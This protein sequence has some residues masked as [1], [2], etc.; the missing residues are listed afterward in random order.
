M[1]LR[2]K[3]FRLSTDDDKQ[4]QDL[5]KRESLSEAQVIRALIT[6]RY[7]QVERETDEE[8]EARQQYEARLKVIRGKRTVSE[9]LRAYFDRRSSR[10]KSPAARQVTSP[11]AR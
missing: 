5:A 6:A 1:R 9:E 11:Q 10:A 8:R 4:L 3:K 7:E 2:Q